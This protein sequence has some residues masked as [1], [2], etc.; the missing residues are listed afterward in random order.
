MRKGVPSRGAAYLSGN[1]QQEANWTA[2]N[3][4]WDDVGLPAGG[5]VSWRGPRLAALEAHFGRPVTRI[6][7]EEQL[8]YMMMELDK[9]QYREAKRLF[10][11]PNATKRQLIRASKIYWGYGEEGSRYTYAEQI[12]NQL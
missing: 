7:P 3:P 10:Y 11:L 6:L 9:P 1:I 8:E 4:A 5:L 2:N 12:L